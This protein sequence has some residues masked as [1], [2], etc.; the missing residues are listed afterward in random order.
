[1]VWLDLP[2]VFS[3]ERLGNGMPFAWEDSYGAR[4]GV[5][6]RSDGS[7][8]WF[9]VDPCYIFH[10]GNARE[11]AAGQIMLDA[12]RYTP[13]DFSR[14]WERIG[15]SDDP[16][17]QAPGGHLHRWSFDL[18]SGAV[19]EERLDDRTVEFPTFNE[20]RLG[21]S[22]RFLYAVG[23]D[24]IVKYDTESGGSRIRDLGAEP[25]EAV[26]VPRGETE[27]DGWLM[28]IVTG[29]TGSALRILDAGTLEDVASVLL[30]RRVPNGFH[31]NW[32]DDLS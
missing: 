14:V 2:V 20:G 15:G 13:A 19:K 17:T 22:S 24:E 31:G 18:A 9:D 10:T 26:F 28:S 32:F 21:R 3:L 23:G 6:R 27:D 12:V 16:A 8:Q 11:N 5:M 7:T 30:P 1:V 25:G 29:E 4:I